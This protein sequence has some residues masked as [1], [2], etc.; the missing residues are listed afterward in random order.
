[1]KN[2]VTKK[3]S[4]LSKMWNKILNLENSLFPEL[5][6]QLGTLSTKEEKR[7]TN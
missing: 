4:S 5:K 2:I 1:M 6:E 7:K 3:I